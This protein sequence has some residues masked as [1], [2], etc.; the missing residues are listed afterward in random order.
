MKLWSGEK[1]FIPAGSAKLV[2]VRVEGD[3][4][5]EGFVDSMLSEEQNPGTFYHLSGKETFIFVENHS[6]EGVEISMKKRL[7]TIHRLDINLEPGTVSKRSKV[8]PLNPDQKRNLKDQIDEWIKQAVI[9][10]ANSPRASPLVPVK[11]T[12]K[13]HLEPEI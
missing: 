5:G 10:P 8:R 2:K 7:G 11:K 1:V 6:N 13:G 4:R 9:E 12:D 3:W